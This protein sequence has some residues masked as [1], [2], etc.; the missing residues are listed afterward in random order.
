MDGGT[1]PSTQW[2]MVLHAGEGS[3]VE[4]RSAMESLCCRYWYPL[5]AFVRRQGRPHHEAEDCT[6]EFLARLLANEVVA[7]ARPERGRF[8]SFLLTALRHFLTDEWH[9]A[10]AAKRGGGQAPLPLEFGKAEQRYVLEPVDPALT[11]EQ[12]FERSWAQ[13]IIDHAIR[14]LRKN[15]EKSG[16][17]PLFEALEPLIW[18]DS[19]LES[20]AELAQ[21]IGMN[22]HSLTVALQRLRLRLGEQ[23]RAEVAHTVADPAEVDAELRDLIRAMVG[24]SS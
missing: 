18:H 13:G 17:G 8:R 23:L 3:A 24:S 7:R 5:Y 15:Y 11:P 12:A 1:F 2:S 21:R 22:E 6:Q 19:G 20:R 10:G 14:E 16:H 9:R 4:A